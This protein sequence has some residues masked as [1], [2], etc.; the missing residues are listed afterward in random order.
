M[1]CILVLATQQSRDHNPNYAKAASLRKMKRLN[2]VAPQRSKGYFATPVPGAIHSS[3]SIDALTASEQGFF[4]PIDPDF[5]S[6][7]VQHQH[8]VVIHF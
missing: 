4:V 8:L 1:E 5:F 6:K 2:V 3:R 7:P